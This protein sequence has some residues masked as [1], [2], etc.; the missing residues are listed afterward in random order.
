[1]YNCDK[2]PINNILNTNATTYTFNFNCQGYN[3]TQVSKFGLTSSASKNTE[4]LYSCAHYISKDNIFIDQACDFSDYL[5]SGV[6]KCLG[7]GTCSFDL[8]ISYVRKSCLYSDLPEYFFLTYECFD[9]Y[10]TLDFPGYNVNIDRQIWAFVIVGTDIASILV[11]LICMIVISIS[12]ARLEE[13]YNNKNI[14]ISDYTVKVSG[15]SL[16][17]DKIHEELTELIR[18]FKINLSKEN[19]RDKYGLSTFKGT[20]EYYTKMYADCEEKISK[21]YINN[22]EIY[23]INYPIITDTKLRLVLKY[24]QLHLRKKKLQRKLQAKVVKT[25]TEEK[26]F[27]LDQEVKEVQ[28]R[29]IELDHTELENIKEIYITFR[30]QKMAGFYHDLY[31]RGRCKRCCF[32]MCCQFKKIKHL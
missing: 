16:S 19:P 29:I 28:R 2:I 14:L 21:E 31:R 10:V 20:F 6:S 9:N 8:D 32:I 11:L 15:V 4:N 27:I 26:I 3:I 18:H 1:M 13:N 24:Q 5:N 17:F 22:T 7:K 23:D 30:N 25:K 12:Q